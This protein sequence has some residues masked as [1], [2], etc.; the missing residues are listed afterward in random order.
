[1][2]CELCEHLERVWPNL[3]AMV[4]W[5]MLGKQDRKH[6]LDMIKYLRDKSGK[7]LDTAGE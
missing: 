5:S 7:N 2:T 3:K 4:E 1:M 6:I